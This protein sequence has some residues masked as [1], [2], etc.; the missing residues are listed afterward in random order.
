[1][2]IYQYLVNLVVFSL[3]TYSMGSEWNPGSIQCIRQNSH[4]L[5]KDIFFMYLE[6][7]QLP[8]AKELLDSESIYFTSRS[9]Q[10]IEEILEVAKAKYKLGQ[11]EKSRDQLASFVERLEYL[12]NLAQPPVAE[13]PD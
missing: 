6:N 10:S 9:G 5:K 8:P 1:M 4:E 2:K 3:N 11:D 7:G 12:Q 13:Q